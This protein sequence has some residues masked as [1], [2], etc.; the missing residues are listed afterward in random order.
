MRNILKTKN[1]FISSLFL[2][3]T[4][5]VFAQFQI[6]AK[7]TKV[8]EQTSVYD[9]ANLL[10]PD[11]KKALETKLINYADTTSTQIVVAIIPSLEGES[12]GMLAPKWA[13]EWGI[14]EKGKDNG[15]FIL[16]AEKERKIWIAPGYGLEHILTAGI[17]GEIIRNY[18]IPEFKK[19]D[20]YQGLNVGTTQLMKL[21][22]GT[23]KGER[24]N[25]PKDSSSIPT[26][27]IVFGVIA[28]LIIVSVIKGKKG[29]N[30][31]NRGSGGFNGPDLFDIIVLS[32]MGR[33]GGGSFGGGF[34]SGSS[35]GG[36]GGGG[37]SGGGAG[38]SW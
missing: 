7:P 2:L 35:G 25:N 28:F 6:P 19:G 21:F 10:K 5:G 17:N 8:T 38:G 20:Y 13:H 24:K 16:L 31:N 18:I 23:Y 33:G 22:S 32:R 12:E 9:Y 26:F 15:V 36:F 11:Q 14:G 34:G 29:G 4:I 1:V 37:F 27:V 3:F 30:G